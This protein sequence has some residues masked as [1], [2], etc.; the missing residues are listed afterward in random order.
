[1]DETCRDG[2]SHEGQIVKCKSASAIPPNVAISEIGNVTLGITV[3]RSLRR[4]RNITSTTSTTLNSSV[5]CTSAIAA[6]I[7][8]VRSLTTEILSADGNEARS[9]GSSAWI[10]STTSIVFAPGWR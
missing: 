6:R 9:F 1:D 10:A 2:Q 5:N 3:A 4:N 7:V 8:T